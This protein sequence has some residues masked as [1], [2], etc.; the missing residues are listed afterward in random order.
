MVY[1]RTVMSIT[2]RAF[3]G[4]SAAGILA[5]ACG[6]TTKD[7]IAQKKEAKN[8]IFCVSDGMAISVPTMVDQFSQLKDAKPSYWAA[9]MNEPYA[10]TGLQ[11]TR[12]LSSVVTDSA[13]T[14][15]K[16]RRYGPRSSATSRPRSSWPWPARWR[17][18]TSHLVPTDPRT[19]AAFLCR[20]M[21]AMPVIAAD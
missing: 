21:D 16:R 18:A 6:G 14:L 19:F 9:L 4:T 17:S 20:P 15:P 13:Q 10:T 7:P 12:S 11:S 8:I 3:L 2:R 5:A 1:A